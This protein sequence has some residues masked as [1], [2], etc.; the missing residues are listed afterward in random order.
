RVYDR[1]PIDAKGKLG[2]PTITVDSGPEV[3]ELARWRVR[4]EYWGGQ[5][6]LNLQVEARAGAIKRGTKVTFA[7]PAK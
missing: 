5:R 1:V 2:E 3:V 7:F 4:E 6:Y